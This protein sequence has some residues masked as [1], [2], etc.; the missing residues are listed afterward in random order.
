MRVE[1]IQLVISKHSEAPMYAVSNT[2]LVEA[3]CCSQAIFSHTLDGNC[4]SDV[5]CL[6]SSVCTEFPANE[7]IIVQMVDAG[8]MLCQFANLN[9][10]LLRDCLVANCLVLRDCLVANAETLGSACL[11]PPR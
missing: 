9:M 6:L 8:S 5:E 1:L 2:E 4:T 3:L 7:S 11:R 10:A